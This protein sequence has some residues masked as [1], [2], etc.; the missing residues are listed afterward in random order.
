MLKIAEGELRDAYK[1]TDKQ[2]RYAAV[3]AVKAKVKAAF[4]P[5]GE[6]SAEVDR[7]AGRAPCSRSC[8]PRSSA[9]TSSTPAPA[10]TAAT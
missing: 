9:G 10:S 4:A 6:E 2:T 8:R 3:D 5:Q 1:I 7:R